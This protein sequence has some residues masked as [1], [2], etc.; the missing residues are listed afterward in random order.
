MVNIQL[1][2][3]AFQFPLWDT[4]IIIISLFEHKGKYFQ[5]PLWD[6]FKSVSVEEVEWI[7][8]QFPLWDTLCPGNYANVYLNNFQFP[9]W[10][11]FFIN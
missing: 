9:L 1:Q 4:A 7:N 3:Q 5:F 6:T 11:T 10:D 2:H 8:F